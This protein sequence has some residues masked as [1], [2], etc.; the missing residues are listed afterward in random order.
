MHA[1]LQPALLVGQ[2]VGPSVGRLVGRSRFTF[3]Y[4]FTSL[5]LLLLPE[6]SGDIKYGPCP[7]APDFGS[8][9]ADL[10]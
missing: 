5:T 8:R 10:V 9:V 7:P 6:W 3:L 4:D 2:L 1:T